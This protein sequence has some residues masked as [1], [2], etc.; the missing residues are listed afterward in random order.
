MSSNTYRML[1]L[2]LFIF[3]PLFERFPAFSEEQT[4]VQRF[5]SETAN[6]TGFFRQGLSRTVNEQFHVFIVSKPQ[7]ETR[8]SFCLSSAK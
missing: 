6:L 2:L 8:E 1:V 4:S 7:V 3:F 5:H